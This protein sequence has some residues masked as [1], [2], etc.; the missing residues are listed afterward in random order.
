[1]SQGG[2]FVQQTTAFGTPQQ[3]TRRC[4]ILLPAADGK[5]DNAI[6]QELETN[7]KTVML[8]RARF[9]QQGLKN[10]WEIAPGRRKPTYGAEK[11]QEIVDTTLQTKPYGGPSGVA[12]VGQTLGCKQID[13]EERLAGP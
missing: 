4:R 3:V 2:K 9:A 6:A 10:L 8:R 7:R 1:M 13:G 5:S 12:L 11:I